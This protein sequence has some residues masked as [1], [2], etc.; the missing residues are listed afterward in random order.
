MRTSAFSAA[1]WAVASGPHWTDGGL[2]QR[3]APRAAGGH[4]GGGRRQ[5]R[6][7]GAD[8]AAPCDHGAAVHNGNA[9]RP[10]PPPAV[11]KAP[12]FLRQLLEARGARGAHPRRSRLR[13]RPAR[14]GGAQPAVAAALR[15]RPQRLQRLQR[16]GTRRSEDRAAAP[17]AAAGRLPARCPVPEPREGDSRCCC[18]RT[19]TGYHLAPASG[20]NGAFVAQRGRDERMVND[21]GHFLL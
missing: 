5:H 18:S 11:S 2:L 1:L 14:R 8:Q 4:G 9:R 20:T 17:G 19:G 7:A 3:R 16:P 13:R 15:W 10:V 21:D 6:G 12:A